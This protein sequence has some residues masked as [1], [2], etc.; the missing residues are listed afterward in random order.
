MVPIK[1]LLIFSIQVATPLTK[2]SVILR[3]M[4]LWDL[5]VERCERVLPSLGS[6]TLVGM[7]RPSLIVCLAVVGATAGHDQ[8]TKKVLH[9][10]S[11]EKSPWW[12]RPRSSLFSGNA[13]HGTAS[14]SAVSNSG[15]AAP[16]H[17][18]LQHPAQKL[19][20][21]HPSAWLFAKD[22]KKDEPEAKPVND[23]LEAKPA[24]ADAT[25]QSDSKPVD[26]KEVDG[27]G[28]V[29]KPISE[30]TA[31]APSDAPASTARGNKDGEK[32]EQ[33]ASPSAGAK[34][35]PKTS[36]SRASGAKPPSLEKEAMWFGAK[37]YMSALW[38][39]SGAWPFQQ[40]KMHQ[41]G[42]AADKSATEEKDT[43][44]QKKNTEEKAASSPPNN[45]PDAAVPGK[46]APETSAPAK[47]GTA[48]A[49]PVTQ[50]GAVIDPAGL[51]PGESVESDP[52]SRDAPTLPAPT[53]EPPAAS[54]AAKATD[55][56]TAWLT[57]HTRTKAPRPLRGTHTAALSMAA[58]LHPLAKEEPGANSHPIADKAPLMR[59]SEAVFP[60]F[61]VIKRLGPIQDLELYGHKPWHRPT[62]QQRA[63]Q[64]AAAAHAA[65]QRT[66]AL[67]A[68]AW[69]MPF[70]DEANAKRERADASA[71]R[72]GTRAVGDASINAPASA[73]AQR[74]VAAVDAP[75]TKAVARP[76]AA[77]TRA[78]VPAANFET[79][80]T[81]ALGQPAAS[82]EKAPAAEKTPAAETATATAHAPAAKASG[83]SWHMSHG[84]GDPSEL[85][86]RAR[87][88]EAAAAAANAR[89][90]SL[91]A[92]LKDLST[93]LEATKHRPTG[94]P[95]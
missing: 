57:P 92:K 74:G 16:K 20:S 41:A 29:S 37:P 52:A 28:T 80:A 81:A 46:D 66:A 40:R 89:V 17:P 11:L 35:A 55:L 36:G 47:E 26:R 51:P 14:T 43:S 12:A 91:E 87:V 42:K 38:G 10:S 5:W 85:K 84:R 44:S 75:S 27:K 73:S 50:A 15:N 32:I 88:A 7:R 24:M 34:D 45:G 53:F 31:S 33:R 71:R 72:S 23:E 54:P 69:M 86:E 94:K 48:E 62:M 59:A 68:Q 4:R 64:R 56:E 93:Q 63:V 77:P 25:S 1:T 79:G 82:A 67:W 61:P 22:S 83:G 95:S 8:A 21:L 90:A 58:D 39:A 76:D 70:A 13:L 30:A 78:S 49:S 3:L 19:W 2:L 6:M 9:E 18:M 65:H 60:E